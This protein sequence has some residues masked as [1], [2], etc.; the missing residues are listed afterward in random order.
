MRGNSGNHSRRQAKGQAGFTLV[1][2]L[3]VMIIIAILAAIALPVYLSQ[4]AKGWDANV[5]SDLYNAAIAQAAYNAE[6]SSYTGNVDDLTA[7]GYNRSSNI[8]I[9]IPTSGEQYCMEAFHKGDPER[10]WRIASAGGNVNP[11]VGECP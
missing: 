8:D 4:R 5:Q 3:L 11:E 9:S 7:T 2:L 6:H 1:E 10:I